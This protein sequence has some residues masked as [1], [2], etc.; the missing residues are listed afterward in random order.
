MNEQF[1]LYAHGGP[2]ALKAAILLEKLG[3]TYRLVPLEAF[4]DDAEKGMKGS[5]YLAINPNG[6]VPAIV[7]HEANDFAVWESGAIL[8]YLTDVY[9]KEGQFY[10]RTPQERATTAQW[11]SFQL[12]GLGPVQ[13]NLNYAHLFGFP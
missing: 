3:L 1:T 6:R 13:G 10:G 7:D 4:S 12:S 2:N 5:K 11:L 9:D 8:L